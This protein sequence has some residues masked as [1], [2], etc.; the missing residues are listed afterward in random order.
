MSWE[1]NALRLYL[2][3]TL[4]IYFE[5]ALQLVDD[6]LMS[7]TE[8]GKKTSKEADEAFKNAV[9]EL[10]VYEGKYHLEE[11]DAERVEKADA[12]RVKK[13]VA[14]R[15][16]VAEEADKSSLKTLN[17]LMEK[18]RVREKLITLLHHTLN[19]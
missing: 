7:A 16:K 18:F 1:G 13:N 10:V 19:L 6:A 9:S 17:S 8:A 14:E 15:I 4:L 2:F 11:N 12:E 3:Q 5:S